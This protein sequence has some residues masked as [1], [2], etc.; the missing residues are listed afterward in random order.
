M[1]YQPLK[2]L[3]QWFGTLVPEVSNLFTIEATVFS[4]F[5][6]ISHAYGSSIDFCVEGQFS[7]IPI[8]YRVVIID[9]LGDVVFL[10]LYLHSGLYLCGMD[11]D[12]GIIIVVSIILLAIIWLILLSVIRPMLA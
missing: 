9:V 6:I 8:L 3:L 10:S 4:L 11:G 12:I 5:S 2:L 1:V 7:V